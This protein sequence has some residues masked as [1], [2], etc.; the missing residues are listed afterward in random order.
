MMQALAAMAPF[1]IS[2]ASSSSSSYLNF[3]IPATIPAIAHFAAQPIQ[4]KA[5]TAPPPSP[6]LPPSIFFLI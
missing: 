6:I 2:S 3:K 5:A 1:T 4:A